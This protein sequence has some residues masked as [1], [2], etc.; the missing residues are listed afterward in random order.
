[1][2][3]IRAPITRVK[4]RVRVEIEKLLK[5]LLDVDCFGGEKKQHIRLTTLA[6]GAAIRHKFTHTD[7]LDCEEREMNSTRVSS[8]LNRI[9]EYKKDLSLSLS[10]PSISAC[11]QR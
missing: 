10:R 4:L 2:Y 1:M 7:G 5:N 9:V 8:Q 6:D 3:V 11:N